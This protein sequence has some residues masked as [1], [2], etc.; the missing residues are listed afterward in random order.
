MECNKRQISKEKI[1]LYGEEDVSLPGC[2]PK[3]GCPGFRNQTEEQQREGS[4]SRDSLDQVDQS[5]HEGGLVRCFWMD[6]TNHVEKV[7]RWEEDRRKGQVAEVGVVVAAAV[8]AAAAVQ[9]KPK[10]KKLGAQGT[11]AQEEGPDRCFH[12]ER[13]K[14]EPHSHDLAREHEKGVPVCFRGCSSQVV[15]SQTT[16]MAMDWGHHDHQTLA[17]DAEE[18]EDHHSRGEED[19]HGLHGGGMYTTS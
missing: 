2:S 11:R 17:R 18:E 8:A 9:R 13:V 12:F 1:N 5:C 7:P 19:H 16:R 10:A 4:G 6:H 15:A 3:D 14:E